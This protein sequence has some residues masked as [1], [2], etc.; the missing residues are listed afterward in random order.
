MI[1][2]AP[3]DTRISELHNETKIPS[4]REFVD[5]ITKI[6][7]D[8]MELHENVLVN[9]LGRYINEPFTFRVKHRMPRAT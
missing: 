4:I 1:L 2:S 7:Y 5:K 6:F 8:K 3:Y 9:S